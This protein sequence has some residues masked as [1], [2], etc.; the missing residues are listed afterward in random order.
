M[1]VGQQTRQTSAV[2]GGD[3]QSGPDQQPEIRVARSMVRSRMPPLA[4]AHQ[5]SCQ[6][7]SCCQGRRRSHHVGG[8]CTV[9]PMEAERMGRMRGMGH[10][11]VWLEARRAGAARLVAHRAGCPVA[12]NA[13]PRVAD[14]P[15][16]DEKQ[17]EEAVA[18]HHERQPAQSP[19]GHQERWRSRAPRR[20]GHWTLVPDT[21]TS[22]TSIFCCF[23][24][25]A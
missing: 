21:T 6:G 8:Q 15:A 10:C 7:R 16:E 4:L 20:R 3:W 25:V 11:R 19:L 17:T 24:I 14:R 9:V 5:G 22:Q 13:A 23:L 2:P 12:W 1:A 18:R